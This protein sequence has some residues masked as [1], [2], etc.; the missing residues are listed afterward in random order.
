MVPFVSGCPNRESILVAS[1]PGEP[2]ART[3]PRA[4]IAESRA[5][6]R[7]RRGS[8]HYE[9]AAPNRGCTRLERVAGGGERLLSLSRAGTTCSGCCVEAIALCG[10]NRCRVAAQPPIGRADDTSARRFWRTMESPARSARRQCVRRLL[11]RRPLDRSRP[12]AA[13]A[14]RA[15]AP[16]SISRADRCRPCVRRAS[17]RGA[18]RLQDACLGSS[19]PVATSVACL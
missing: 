1:I 10:E 12:S 17:R 7:A 14:E 5:L 8:A 6:R 11:C 2:R 15:P 19:S 13:G 9:R 4:E 16:R 3:V 18:L